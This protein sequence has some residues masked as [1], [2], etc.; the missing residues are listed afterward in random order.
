MTLMR[1]F[2]HEECVEMSRALWHLTP[3][4]IDH[5]KDAVEI[6]NGMRNK[7]SFPS[8]GYE[9]I[10]YKQKE[11]MLL[12]KSNRFVTMFLLSINIRIIQTASIPQTDT[13]LIYVV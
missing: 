3:T 6:M 7:S 13:V 11:V 4:T 2:F 9:H 5:N 1:L 8:I 12:E 10:A